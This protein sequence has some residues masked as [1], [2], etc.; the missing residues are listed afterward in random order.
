MKNLKIGEVASATGVTTKT[1]RYYELLGLL[2]KPTRTY[3]GY[4]IYHENDLQRLRFIK[5]A[6]GLGLSLIEIKD[7]LA[8]YERKQ[9]PCAHVLALMDKKLEEID[10]VFKDLQSFRADLAQLREESTKR[11][12]SLSEPEGICGIIEQG[13]HL[14]GEQALAWLESHRKQT[15]RDSP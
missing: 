14:R 8:L 1:I 11:L 5:K 7:I 10:M 4:R 6:K 3:S 2:R 15:H 12:K 9:P 13:V